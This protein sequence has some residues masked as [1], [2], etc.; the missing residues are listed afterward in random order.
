MVRARQAAGVAGYVALTG[1]IALILLG[2]ELA[3][4]PATTPIGVPY[5]G[6]DSTGLLGTDHLGRDVLSRVLHGG[7]PML[8]TGAAAAGAG[9]V[10]GV[11]LG[12][13]TAL[14]EAR[15]PHAAALLMRPADAL[16]ALPPILVLMLVLTAFPGRTGIVLAVVAATVPLSARV[17]RAAAAQVVGRAHVE[18]AITRGEGLA[19]LLGR[20]ILPLIAGTVLADAGLRFIT[21]TYLVAA[22]GFLGLGA[23][24]ADWGVLIVE[25][26]A[27]A[28]LAPWALVAPVAA[29]AALTV[30]VNL[31]ADSL[32]R[33]WRAVQA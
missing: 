3:P 17:I 26:L 19:W 33:R 22:A 15:R 25:A 29:F 27:G 13:A 10:L 23:G 8:L 2:P 24:D 21:A 1:L 18:A 31:A 32:A 16:V 4:H 14:I 9:T 11:A 6:P 30:G 28:E 12:M 7:R 5:A 20:E